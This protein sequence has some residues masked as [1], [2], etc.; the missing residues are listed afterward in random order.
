MEDSHGVDQTPAEVKAGLD[1]L[2]AV[3]SS[4]GPPKNDPESID[5]RLQKARAT[6]RE[7][8]VRLYVTSAVVIALLSFA[9]YL[10]MKLG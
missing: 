9:I 3:Q 1:A 6:Q 10:T 4:A 8:I 7:F 2:K 5:E